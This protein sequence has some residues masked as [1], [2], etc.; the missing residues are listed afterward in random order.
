ML[1]QA[2]WSE[3]I[4]NELIGSLAKRGVGTPDRLVRLRQLIKNS[5]ADSL[6]IGH[7]ELIESLKLPD[8]DDRHVLAAAIRSHA[9]VIVTHNAKD[10]PASALE[11]WGI[12]AKNPDDFV[13]DLIDLD[14]WAV[15]SCL[16]DIVAS[17]N[18]PPVT[19]ETVLE[20]LER[21]RLVQT[22]AVMRLG[23]PDGP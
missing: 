14:A 7:E 9:Q 8:P 6:V 17:R 22:A 16:R 23:P 20:Q 19:A 13:R 21:S 11:P 1:I 2:T 4:L 3:Q 12:E 15:H 10:F 18:N 5:I